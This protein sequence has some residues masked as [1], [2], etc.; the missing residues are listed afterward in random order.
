MI[1]A[2]SMVLRTVLENNASGP[3][4]HSGVKYCEYRH[5]QFQII[6]LKVVSLFQRH[7]FKRVMLFEM[8]IIISVQPHALGFMQCIK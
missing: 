5:R 7:M 2:T 4:F 6:L 1:V 3:F 8:D